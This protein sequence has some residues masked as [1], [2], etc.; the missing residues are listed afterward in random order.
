M[1][2]FSSAAPI[3]IGIGTSAPPSMTSNLYTYGHGHNISN[4]GAGTGTKSQS[5]ASTSTSTSASPYAFT[6]SYSHTNTTNFPKSL[7]ELRE[8]SHTQT[9]TPSGT[10]SAS[11]SAAIGTHLLTS[12]GIDASSL[13]QKAKGLQSHIPTSTANSTMLGQGHGQGHGHGTPNMSGAPSASS[14]IQPNFNIHLHGGNIHSTLDAIHS[15]TIH[16]ILNTQFH[17]TKQNIET[18][19][20]KRLNDDWNR[21]REDYIKHSVLLQNNHGRRIIMNDY[22]NNNI[23]SDGGGGAGAGSGS[24]IAIGIGADATATS[25]LLPMSLTPNL[26]MNN[27]EFM[28]QFQNLV[29]SHYNAMT[30]NTTTTTTTTTTSTISEIDMKSLLHLSNELT[31][32]NPIY[33]PYNKAIKLLS[34]L[35]QQQS[36]PHQTSLSNSPQTS[37]S[38]P[39]KQRSVSTLLFLS[40]QFKDY[41]ITKVNNSTASASSSSSS[42]NSSTIQG[43]GFLSYITKYV[44]MEIGRDTLANAT[45]DTVY[46]LIYYCLRCGEIQVAH[47]ILDSNRALK[48]GIVKQVLE[49]LVKTS[50]GGNANNGIGMGGTSN[51]NMSSSSGGSSNNKEE[52]M[53]KLFHGLHTLPNPFVDEMKDLYN[54]VILNSNSGMEE[55]SEY[56]IAVLAMLSFS[57]SSGTNN[58]ATT[59]EDYIYLGL[60]NALGPNCDTLK[61]VMSLGESIKQYGSDYFEDTIIEDSNGNGNGSSIGH[62]SSTSK[63]F[64]CGWAYA[65]PLLLCQC[66]KSGILHLAQSGN[67]IGLCMAIHLALG[68]DLDSY[69]NL[70]LVDL[71]LSEQQQNQAE[72]SLV[73]EHNV[74]IATLL[75]EYVKVL[76]SLSPAVALAYIIHIPDSTKSR[77][78]LKKS[79]KS[80]SQKAE[81]QISNLLLETKAFGV[82]AGEVTSDGSRNTSGVMD[83]YFAPNHVADL[84]AIAADD[85]IREGKIMDACQLLSM[86]G[87]YSSVLSLLNRQLSS[88]VVVTKEDEVINSERMQQRDIWRK[89]SFNFHSMYLS[90]GRTHVLQVLESEGNLS[91]GVD[92]QLILNLMAFFDRCRGDEWT[93]AWELIDQLNILPE[94]EGTIP[95]MI[96]SYHNL[97]SE[98]QQIFHHIIIKSMEC[99]RELHTF[100]KSSIAKVNIHQYGD[101]S[102][103]NAMN[104]SEQRLL[105]IRKRARVLV[106]FAN[107]IQINNADEVRTVIYNM[108]AVMI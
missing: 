102:S 24:A 99:L 5:S 31:H 30:T 87:R 95:A 73:N 100:A 51:M 29:T 80:L 84:L 77:I 79:G 56:E 85:S 65:M 2:T 36:Q 54:R 21:Q 91:F 44:E 76:R 98:I 86:G 48:D 16:E 53:N 25:S 28:N 75:I 88:L 108:E 96:D 93:A 26:N 47:E 106:N 83:E 90:Q 39:V 64:T 78:A 46:R 8:S 3:G 50:C 49:H 22:N 6:T 69:D 33:I 63:S 23:S 27:P 81:K 35:Q 62:Q 104:A 105:E 103:V 57:E 89:V 34:T 97:P 59:I 55:R 20:Q 11:A 14:S 7:S 37:T 92:F 10:T 40:N 70:M 4:T 17:N 60:W 66:Y 71:S 107:W 67:G 41:I 38:S 18:R 12:R 1:N 19:I 43:H 58:I 68:F 32:S 45:K 94:N 9:F 15:Q 82:L 13:F 101:S 61:M 52:Q 72:Q 42:S 74:V